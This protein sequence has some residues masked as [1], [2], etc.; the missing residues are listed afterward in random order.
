[1]VEP[2]VSIH[3]STTRSLE[4]HKVLVTVESPV[5]DQKAQGKVTSIYVLSASALCSHLLST[6]P[7]IPGQN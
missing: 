5:E 7:Y 4:L 6:E 1:M 3:L 2:E